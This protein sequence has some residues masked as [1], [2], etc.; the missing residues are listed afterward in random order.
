MRKESINILKKYRVSSSY[1][2]LYTFCV[3]SFSAYCNVF[4]LSEGNSKHSC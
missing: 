1:Y 4:D 3:F 2:S